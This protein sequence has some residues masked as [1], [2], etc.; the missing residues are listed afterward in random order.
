MAIPAIDVQTAF[1]G[2]IRLS[3]DSFALA[4]YQDIVNAR[5][6]ELLREFIGQ[7]AF[8]FVENNA[9]TP[10]WQ[11]FFDGGSFTDESGVERYQYGYLKAVK[12][13][14][15]FWLLRDCGWVNTV[16]G[17][18][19]NVNENSAQQSAGNLSAVAINRYNEGI[20][21]LEGIR[22]YIR[23]TDY[24]ETNFPDIPTNKLAY[25]Y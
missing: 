24:F 17:N 2:V 23:A 14:L 19:T 22:Q 8:D 5:Y 25:A 18:V 3:F 11:S 4:D 13:Q 15:Y 9:L 1:V 10:E 21:F 20:G 16:T 7:Q 6:P 12:Y